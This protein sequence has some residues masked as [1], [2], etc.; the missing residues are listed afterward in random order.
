MEVATMD[1]TAKPD[2]LEN[3]KRE[4]GRIAAGGGAFQDITKV[5]DFRAFTPA[6]P[7]ARLQE[8]GSTKTQEERGPFGGWLLRQPE[9][10]ARGALI[11]AAKA[12]R[13]FPK[14]GDPDAVRARLN[15]FGAEGD[16]FEAVD[17]AELDW[18]SF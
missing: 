4:I 10:G 15:S 18:S 12:D 13:G 2:V 1:M 17:D 6:P 5:P 8:D 11:K 16:M 7:D 14:D 3:V 9:E